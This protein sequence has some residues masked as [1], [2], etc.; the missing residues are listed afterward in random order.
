MVGVPGRSRACVQCKQRR[1]AVCSPCTARLFENIVLILPKCD[2]RQPE[3]ARCL[4]SKRQCEYSNGHIFVLNVKGGHKTKY[5]K[6][7][8]ISDLTTL[9]NETLARSAR[10]EAPARWERL[11]I[12]PSVDKIVR[13]ALLASGISYGQ[14]AA[15]T[16]AY[17]GI[18]S[19]SLV[20]SADTALYSPALA[21]YSLWRGRQDGNSTVR[22]S[23][24]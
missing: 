18:I 10:S 15:H 6:E 1:I 17:L 11:M 8:A 12:V 9:S 19:S 14:D 13:Q 20:H 24:L 23:W 16:S 21:C 7:C 3:C 2:L 5:R 4:K 22:L